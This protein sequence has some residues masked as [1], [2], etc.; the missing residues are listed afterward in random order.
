MPD[1]KDRI[2]EF[3]EPGSEIAGNVAGAA[4]GLMT[5]GPVGALAGAACGP[6]IT[7]V[8]KRTCLELYD[9]VT[10][11]REKIRA[12]AAAAYAL[13]QIDE[14][15][16]QGEQ[17]R[18]DGFFDS[19]SPRSS[20][21]EILEGV[22][23]KSRNEHEERKTKY[24]A[25][26]LA[27]AAFDAGFSPATLNHTLTLAERLTYRQMC[28]LH[29]FSDPQPIPLRDRD[30]R[31]AAE[32]SIGWETVAVLAEVF[33]LYQASLVQRISGSGGSGAVIFNMFYIHPSKMVRRPFGDRLHYLMQLQTI[34][35]KH[36]MEVALPLTK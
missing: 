24:Y 6:V 30:Y 19:D 27:T 5:A 1:D 33:D 25:N 36:L 11:K 2:R 26:I 21:D 10:S 9:R 29:L 14:R 8:F 34:P 32:S 12:G 20:A 16:Q 22:I 4:I 28:L 31:G 13:T 15:I 3:I 35:Q 17:L 7:S 18:D 23:I